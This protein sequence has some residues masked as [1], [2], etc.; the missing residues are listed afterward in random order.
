MLFA[1]DKI[2]VNAD[3]FIAKVM[4]IAADLQINANWLMAY[5]NSET[6]GTFDPSIRNSQSGAV[7]LAQIL[8]STAQGLGTTA[9]ALAGMS[10][11]D[12]LSW[13]EAYFYPYRNYIT[14]YEDLYLIGF[15]PNADGKTAGTLSKPDTWQFPAAVQ[16]QNPGIDTIA[17]FKAFIWKNI[18][19]DQVAAINADPGAAVAIKKF[20]VRNAVPIVLTSGLLI[21]LGTYLIITSKNK[22]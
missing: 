17:D 4:A 12:Q 13:V 5:M 9:D 21:A 18:P 22:K 20:V 14:S 2:T 10:N 7:G 3:A 1:Q 15:Y 8:P 11:V 6:G 16:S 19:P